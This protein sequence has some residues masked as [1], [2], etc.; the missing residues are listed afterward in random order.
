MP[1][2]IP[3]ELKEVFTP[4]AQKITGGYWKDALTPVINEALF[5]AYTLGQQ[6]GATHQDKIAVDR[7]VGS[8]IKLVNDVINPDMQIETINVLADL[9]TQIQ[10][11]KK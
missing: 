6:A 9:I 10:N 8:C 1:T 7:M 3:P 11:L 2:N 4:L 5:E